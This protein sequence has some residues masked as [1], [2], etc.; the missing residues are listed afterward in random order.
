MRPKAAVRR[1]TVDERLDGTLIRLV[2][3]PLARGVKQITDSLEDWRPER[4]RLVTPKTFLRHLGLGRNT[5]L[6]QVAYSEVA[7]ESGTGSNTV[8]RNDRDVPV[9][10]RLWRALAEGQVFIVGSFRIQGERHDPKAILAGNG[11]CDFLRIDRI[12][13]VKNALKKLY[14]DALRGREVDSV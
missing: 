7:G 13:F 2:T 1:I 3:A 5:N 10:E 4:E 14:S 9:S 12:P 8:L 11:P 6:I